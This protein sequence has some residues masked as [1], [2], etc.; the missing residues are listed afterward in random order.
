MARQ[1]DSRLLEGSYMYKYYTI[2]NNF[3]IKW[4]I[5]KKTYALKLY[6]LQAHLIWH[7]C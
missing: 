4:K 6:D 7:K 1:S 2:L 5:C 3:E